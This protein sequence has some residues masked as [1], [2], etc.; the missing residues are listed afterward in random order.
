[1]MRSLGLL[2]CAGTSN[3]LLKATLTAKDVYKR[4]ELKALDSE[5]FTISQCCSRSG[6]DGCLY[7]FQRSLL[8]SEVFTVFRGHRGQSIM[9]DIM[10]SDTTLT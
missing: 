5:L 7:C 10:E 1:M 6:Q 3:S 2:V 8:F 9:A 4:R